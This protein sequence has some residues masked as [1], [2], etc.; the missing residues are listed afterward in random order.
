MSITIEKSKEILANLCKMDLGA[1]EMIETTPFEEYDMVFQAAIS[2]NRAVKKVVITTMRHLERTIE[3]YHD[4][5]FYVLLRKIINKIELVE[6]RM[7]NGPV[8]FKLYDKKQ[9]LESP[10]DPKE[11]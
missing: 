8:I 7:V 11:E 3:N 6:S 10:E 9:S 1:A 5:E 2:S 4:L